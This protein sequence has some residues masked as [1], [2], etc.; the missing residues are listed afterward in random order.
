MVMTIASVAIVMMVV[1]TTADMKLLCEIFGAKALAG[2]C[3]F[4]AVF[5]CGWYYAMN[6]ME[7]LKYNPR[8][9]LHQLQ[10]NTFDP[11]QPQRSN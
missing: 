6:N 5:G 10:P 8:P 11:S 4:L 3:A 2:S 1:A 7:L 9:P